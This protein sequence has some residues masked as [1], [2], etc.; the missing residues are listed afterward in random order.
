MRMK[1]DQKEKQME[2]EAFEHLVQEKV[3]KCASNTISELQIIQNY[4]VETKKKMKNW[5]LKKKIP[6]QNLLKNF[7]EEAVGVMNIHPQT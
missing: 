2:T 7:L 6:S 1:K 4:L 3:K 5:D